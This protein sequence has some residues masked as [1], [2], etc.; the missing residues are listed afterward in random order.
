[1][2]P[3]AI[4]KEAVNK[5][6]DIIGICDHNSAE[7]CAAVVKAAKGKNLTV[8]PGIEA[9]SKE[10]V[11]IVALFENVRNV[12]KLQNL[13]YDNLV[14]ENNPE[15]FGQ[16]VIVDAEGWVK[17]FNPRLLIG[18]TGLTIEQLVESIHRFNGLAVA[19][20]IDREG[21]GII[22]QLGFIPPDLKFDG[23][24][25]SSRL[26]LTEARQKFPEYNNYPF[27][28]SSDAHRIAE[29]GQ[30][31]TRWSMEAPGFKELRMALEGEAGRGF[32]VN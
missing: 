23:L 8:L 29:I 30:G 9:A 22:G 11:H 3:E 16:Q 26:S 13:I 31:T 21:F 32:I 15:V 5:N 4:V 10:E 28:C 19:A 17:G 12:L 24:E 20:H 14:G 6:I 7:N 25:I 1:M 27:I 18:A 2:S